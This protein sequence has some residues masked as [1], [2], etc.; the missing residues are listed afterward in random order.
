[1]ALYSKRQFADHAGIPT[2]NLSKYIERGHVVLYGGEPCNCTKN[3]CKCLIDDQNDKNL[4]FLQRRGALNTNNHP[5]IA[6]STPKNE[7]TESFTESKSESKDAFAALQRRKLEHQ[8]RELENKNRLLETKISKAMAEV[9]PLDH[10]EYLIKNYA[11]S[12]ANVWETS[13][14]RFLMQK[15]TALR[16]TREEIIEHKK[17]ITE[18]VNDSRK[19][20]AESAVKNMRKVADEFAGTKGKG[21]RE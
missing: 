12:I 1:M 2:N 19:R 20:G 7:A 18:L 5:E 14:E 21:E 13:T 3:K 11:D 4:A 17:Y 15:G 6:T 16:L 8:N 9:I 10:A